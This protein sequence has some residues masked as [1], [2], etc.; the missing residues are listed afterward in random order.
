V[1]GSRAFHSE[2]LVEDLMLVGLPGSVAAK[3]RGIPFREL[4]QLPLV[5]PDQRSTIR[6]R[7]AKAAAG[8]ETPIDA[9]TEIDSLDLTKQAVM[10]GMGLTIL[11]PV[12]FRAEAERGDLIG[13]PIVE[14]ELEQS[15]LWAIQPN[16]R[17]PRGTYNEV[18][19]AVFEEWYSAVHSG[20]WPAIWK[21]DLSR[22]SL[23][24]RLEVNSSP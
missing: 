23:P 6:T 11:P 21:L 8:A 13:R 18:E 9:V 14:P 24:L 3:G 22:L 5:L 17:I 16:W 12:A 15:V 19:R 10:A 7:L 20:E 4:R 1:P 2:V